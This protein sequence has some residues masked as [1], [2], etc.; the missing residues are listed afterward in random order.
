MRE[1]CMSKMPPTAVIWLIYYGCAVSASV[2]QKWPCKETL[3]MWAAIS[4]LL[5]LLTVFFEGEWWNMG[6]SVRSLCH[7]I[8][9]NWG[10]FVHKVQLKPRVFLLAMT[11]MIRCCRT[12]CTV[13][14]C[15]LIS[16]HDLC[17]FCLIQSLRGTVAASQVSKLV[18]PATTGKLHDKF[19]RAL[20]SP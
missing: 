17:S 8:V 5:S 3:N 10:V 9:D 4:H 2:Q 20:F 16:E 11:E 12:H 1:E 7:H 14:V 13:A 15:L 19:G 18:L 6:P